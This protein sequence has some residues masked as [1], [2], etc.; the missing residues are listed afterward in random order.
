[1]T[2]DIPL[3]WSGSLVAR[4]ACILLL[5]AGLSSPASAAEPLGRLFFSPEE[6]QAFDR[7]REFKAEEKPETPV[8]EASAPEIPADP[9]LTINGIVTR[10]SGKRTVWINGV[11]RNENENPGGVAIVTNRKSPGEVVVE[12][13]D[14]QSARANVGDTVNRNTGEAGGLLG[15][16]RLRVNSPAR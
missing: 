8:P 5:A 11:A 2:Q 9:T 7:R 15:G 12:L 13:N 3:F 16:G 10:S 1:M 6:R 14:K 4:T